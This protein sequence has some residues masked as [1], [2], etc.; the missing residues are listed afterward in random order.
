[1]IE[2]INESTCLTVVILSLISKT[3]FK[4]LYPIN[5]HM[6]KAADRLQTFCDLQNWPIERKLASPF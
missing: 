5:S 1:L 6:S 4:C 3:D 2:N